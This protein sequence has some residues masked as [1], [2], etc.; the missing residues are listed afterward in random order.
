MI[1]IIA[2]LVLSLSVIE[3]VPTNFDALEFEHL[4]ESGAEISIASEV[5][6]ILRLQNYENQY[7]NAPKKTDPESLGVITTASSAIVVDNNSKMV[8]FEKN[9]DELRSI[10]SL[11]KLMTA[12][13]FLE[14]NPNLE[15]KASVTAEDVRLGGRD[16]LYVNDYITVRQMLEASLIGSDNPA[17]MSLARLSGLSVDEFVSKMNEFAKAFNMNSTKFVD[18]TG[19]NSRN[20]ST[21]REIAILLAHALEYSEISSITS[22]NKS[23]FL[24]ESGRH[25][26]IQ[27]TNALLESYLNEQPFSI[28]GGKTGFLPTAGYCLGLKVNDGSGHSVLSVVL[29]SD[30]QN[31]RFQEVK[32]L[33]QW[34]F[35]VYSWPDEI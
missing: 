17:T 23:E 21:A 32:G 8:L 15:E 20:I 16:H 24:S 13:V 6:D 35:D 3:M 4:P 2:Q 25:Y 22:K 5:V 29:G 11:T 30:T 28:V 10:G 12:I 27:S 1:K 9:A 18:Q 14:S 31:S 7:S 19:L 34:A 33:T 26:S